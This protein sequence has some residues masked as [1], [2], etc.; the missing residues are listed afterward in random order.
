MYKLH[1]CI[2][3]I[4][5]Y[6]LFPL[7][8]CS[9]SLWDSHIAMWFAMHWMKSHSKNEISFIIHSSL[10][11]TSTNN[12]SPKC[13]HNQTIRCITMPYY[14]FAITTA[15]VL[16]IPAI[17][18]GI[19]SGSGSCTVFLWHTLCMHILTYKWF[20]FRF[21]HRTA[22]QSYSYFQLFLSSILYRIFALMPIAAAGAANTH[23]LR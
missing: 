4:A 12:I 17:R 14:H 16:T 3:S 2:K 6:S 19:Y 15:L 9:F 5:V 20:S 23:W 13:A 21:V 18:L 1:Q 7:P 8:F 11:T 10:F 22:L